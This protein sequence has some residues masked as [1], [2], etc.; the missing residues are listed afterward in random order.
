MYDNDSIQLDS[1]DMQS[2]QAAFFNVGRT[3]VRAGARRKPEIHVQNS[4]GATGL[5][6]LSQLLELAL[7]AGRANFLVAPAI[8]CSTCNPAQPIKSTDV[9]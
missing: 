3:L 1:I 9:L 2:V 6:A 5:S 8:Y 7:A 4:Q